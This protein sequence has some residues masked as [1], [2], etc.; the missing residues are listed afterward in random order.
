MR[1]TLVV[2][3]SLL[4][5]TS[6]PLSAQMGSIAFDSIEVNT[7]KGRVFSD[8]RI[9]QVQTKDGS[10][11]KSLLYAESMWLGGLDGG[12]LRQSTITYRQ[13]LFDFNPG[14]ISND[15]NAFAKY[16]KVYKVDLITLSNFKNGLT[17]SIPPQIANWPAHGDTTMG[18]AYYLAPFV[19][20]NL[21]GKYDPTDGDYPKIK[22][23]EAVYV[24]FNDSYQRLGTDLGVE[25]HA[26][27]YGFS[28]GGIEDSIL[29]KEYTVINRSNRSYSDMYLSIFADFDIGNSLD[30][31]VGTSISSNSIFSYNGDA[32][33]NA[34]QGFGTNLATCGVRMLTGPPAD[35]ADGIDNDKDGCIDAVRD[36]NGNCIPESQANGLREQILL[37]GSMAYYNN[38]STQGNPFSPL[39][40]YNYQRSFWRNGNNLII[41]TPSGILDPNNGDGYV[42]SNMGP[43]TTFAFPGND[44]DTSGSYAP[45]SPVNWFQP[46]SGSTD[47]RILANAGPFSLLGGEEF[48]TTIGIIWDRGDTT[49]NGYDAINKLLGGLDTIY[50]NSPQQNVSLPRYH[51]V[52]PFKVFYMQNSGWAVQ[53]DVG[54]PQEF[55]L[56]NTNGQLLRQFIVEPNKTKLIPMKQLAQG[57][58]LIVDEKT[59]KAYKLTQ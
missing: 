9:G 24:I 19:D 33:D 55:K 13:A 18:E 16:N 22:G 31:L 46:S 4:I 37:S 30:D 27:V 48:T 21:D 57:V 50:A 54:S 17:T 39:E 43:L 1:K 41:E 58:Y 38:N 35:I 49:N 12:T 44:I 47:Q 15:P 56:Y 28:T 10:T 23:D 36:A 42:Q 11:Y 53:N 25:I 40:S 51:Y 14:P 6:Y 29:Y 7:L 59:A 2:L 52:D 3:T 26:M 8:G 32:N 45:L 20:V 5:T 34:P